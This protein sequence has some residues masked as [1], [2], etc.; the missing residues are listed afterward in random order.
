MAIH[1]GI[2]LRV[3][4]MLDAFILKPELWNEYTIEY[5]LNKHIQQNTNLTF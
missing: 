3:G 1:S 4:S 5:K 2:S